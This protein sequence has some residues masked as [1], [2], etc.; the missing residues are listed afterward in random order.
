MFVNISNFSKTSDYLSIIS[1]AILTDLFVIFTLIIGAMQPKTLKEWYNKYGLSAIIADVLVIVIV[2]ILARFI[3]PFLFKEYSIFW[4]SGL[5]VCIQLIHDILFAQLCYA[6]PRGRS[7]IMDTFKDYA[8][9]NGYIILLAD[10]MMV[11]STIIIASLLSSFSFNV[12]IIVFIIS[13]Y[14]IPYFLYS[15]PL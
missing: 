14:I 10:A 15:I 2:I 11:V 9:E 5:A 6:M 13:I 1:G 3:Y 12:N 4:F 8:T 7:E